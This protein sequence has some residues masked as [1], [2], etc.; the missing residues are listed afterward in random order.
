VVDTLP[1]SVRGNVI[2]QLYVPD[3]VILGGV[4]DHP[5]PPLGLVVNVPVLQSN[6]PEL[7]GLAGVVD[8]VVVV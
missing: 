6:V 1:S 3:V 2:D 4:K 7:V 5:A 8:P